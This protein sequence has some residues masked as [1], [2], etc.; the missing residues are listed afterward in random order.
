MI[1]I[2]TVLLAFPCGYLFRSHLAANVAYTAAYLWA[3]VFQGL[4]LT[5]NWV[6]GDNSAFP[7][8]PDTLPLSY[9]LVSLVILGVRLGLVALG[10]RV[11]AGH[12]NRHVVTS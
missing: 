1:A 3:F 2:V 12:R 4:Y 8:D 6:G 10:C 9:G 7:K 5:R 11:G